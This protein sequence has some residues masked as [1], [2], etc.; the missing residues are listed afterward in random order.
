M[1]TLKIGDWQTGKVDNYWPLSRVFWDLFGSCV[2]DER[3]VDWGKMNGI[4]CWLSF[5]FVFQVL[6]SM[7]LY[8]KL[9][10]IE[11]DWKLKKNRLEVLNRFFEDIR[12]MK[13]IPMYFRKRLGNPMVERAI[14]ILDSLRFDE[15]NSYFVVLIAPNSQFCGIFE[16][17]ILKTKKKAL[18]IKAFFKPWWGWRDSNP[19]PLRCERSALTSWATSPYDGYYSI[20]C[21]VLQYLISKLNT[22]LQMSSA[23]SATFIIFCVIESTA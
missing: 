7:N 22:L 15:W 16:G 11:Y 12:G 1:R 4:I 17:F 21:S 8:R 14:A 13:A 3:I 5:V 20:A 9:E 10:I 18:K 6:K 2:D 19:R 23:F